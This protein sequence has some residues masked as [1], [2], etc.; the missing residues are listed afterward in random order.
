MSISS[1]WLIDKTLSGTATPSQNGF[2]SDGSEEVLR[3]TQCSCITGT[4]PSDCLVLYPGQ[5][6]SVFY[7]PSWLGNAQ[8]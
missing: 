4:S 1:V 8:S 6:V 3:I 2:V 7:S 5:A